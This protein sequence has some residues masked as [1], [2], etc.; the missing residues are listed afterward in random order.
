MMKGISTCDKCLTVL[1]VRPLTIDFAL[2]NSADH[3]DKPHYAA[4]HLGPHR[5][6]T[7]RFYFLVLWDHGF[8]LGT[9][10]IIRGSLMRPRWPKLASLAHKT[11]TLLVSVLLPKDNLFKNIFEYLL[12]G[13]KSIGY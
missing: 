9:L 1:H 5:L 6:P 12:R 11:C 13:F 3:D 2:S 8:H 7:C 4:C 10:K